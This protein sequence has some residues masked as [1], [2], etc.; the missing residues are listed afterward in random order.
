MNAMLP[1]KE[2]GPM[3]TLPYRTSLFFSHSRLTTF[4]VTGTILLALLILGG[5]AYSATYYIHADF[6]DDA[7]SG[8]SE[9][10]PWRT[11]AQVAANEFAPGDVIKLAGT[12]STEALDLTGKVG[13]TISHW[14]AHQQP[15]IDGAALLDTDPCRLFGSDCTLDRIQVQHAAP[16]NQNLYCR[17]TGNT[18][19]NCVFKDP[20][21]G[22]FN[23]KL[24]GQGTITFTKNVVMGGGNGKDVVIIANSP[25]VAFSYNLVFTTDP[26][27]TAGAA[28]INISSGGGTVSLYNN[29]LFGGN[30]A[31]IIQADEPVQ[32]AVR[33]NILG[34]ANI[35][36][37]YNGYLVRGYGPNAAIIADYNLLIPNATQQEGEA[38]DYLLGDYVIDGGHNVIDAPAFVQNPY[39]GYLIVAVDDSNHQ[40][41]KDLADLVESFGGKISWFVNHKTMYRDSNPSQAEIT[42]REQM[43]AQLAT[44]GHDIACH[45]WSHSKLNDYRAMTLKYNGV[46]DCRLTISNGVL[47]LLPTDLNYQLSLS[48]A[49]KTCQD[50]LDALAAAGDG[51]GYTAAMVEF[52]GDVQ[53]FGDAQATS[54]ADV[55]NQSVSSSYSLLFDFNRWKVD[56]IDDAVA[57]IEG[58][59]GMPSN[60]RV[61]TFA[62]PYNA[63][64]EEWLSYLR[65]K[66]LASRAGGGDFF[67]TTANSIDLHEIGF[68]ESTVFKGTPGTYSDL[69]LK[70]RARWLGERLSMHGAVSCLY[71]HSPSA[72]T[73]IHEWSV[74]LQEL[75]THYPR[76]HLVSLRQFYDIVTA[77]DSGWTQVNNSWVRDVEA[78]YDLR[79]LQSSPSVDAGTD[80]GLAT[81]Y[82]GIVVP[83]GQKPDVGLYEYTTPLLYFPH[84]ASN[85]FWE[86]EIGLFNTSPNQTLG[87]TLRCYDNTGQSVS[88]NTTVYLGPGARREITVGAQ[89]GN[90]ERIGYLI[91]ET[92]SY[93]ARGYAKFYQP[94]KYRV[95]IPAVTEINAED[96]YLPHIASNPTWWTGLSLLNTTPSARQLTMEF[97]NAVSVT[98]TLAPQEHQA[99]T[100]SQLFN[101]EEQ[102]GI[103]SAVIRNGAGVIGLE[104]FGGKTA[105]ELGGIPLLDHLA[106]TLYFPH[107]TTGSN[108]WTGIVAANPSATPVT[109]TIT[110][111]SA[112]GDAL[113]PPVPVS[114]GAHEKY[115]GTVDTLSLPADTAWFEV[116]ST[117]PVSGFELFGSA[118][119]TQLAEYSGMDA[120]ANAGIF[121]KLEKNGWT[122]IVLVNT[123]AG[124]ASLTLTARTNTG[125]VIASAERT[126]GGRAKLLASA[127]TIF[128]SQELEQTTYIAYSA[129]KELV[130]FQLNGSA[131][132]LLLDSLPALH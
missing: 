44:Q 17:G 15:I 23:V 123:E 125:Y 118:A 132:N 96:I 114:L 108:W 72:E 71:A 107:V 89:F 115:I 37:P 81:D 14:E 88:S 121:P 55:N 106:T 32:T 127:D 33:N 66:F 9:S 79:L 28:L 41:A 67:S 4:L 47:Q 12:F 104:L 61:T 10:A 19:T 131:D 78:Q 36:H 87:G 49:G 76:V 69:E 57:W 85:S 68:L 92:S 13:I 77:P 43:A 86:T 94:D 39:D 21:G 6:G 75:T 52:G 112:S 38:L 101:G 27:A 8:T 45:A 98:R 110:P 95:G 83:Q 34:P 16:G 119:G 111:Y 40:Y 97:D 91:F 100:I 20:S 24:G 59:A 120:T 116:S 29:N 70:A 1:F 51:R 42:V 122:G 63:Y 103:H 128:S 2:A 11:L 93:D 102:P 5:P 26:A 129:D 54:L 3:N 7:N 31:V 25:S 82:G 56:E 60:Y 90:P 65:T 84:I 105:D 117:E 22:A 124:S 48:L 74:M 18:I 30:G 64:N 58:I 73:S 50:I 46:G 62:A 99:F 109:L 35:E 113:P 130:A 53:Q 126:L 80:V